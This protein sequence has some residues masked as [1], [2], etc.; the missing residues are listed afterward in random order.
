MSRS[1]LARWHRLPSPLPPPWIAQPRRARFASSTSSFP[2]PRPGRNTWSGFVYPLLLLS[3]V[4]SLTMNLR[5]T[6][7]A[8]EEN[9]RLLRSQISVLESLVKWLKSDGIRKL[10]DEEIERR[11]QRELELVGLRERQGSATG[12]GGQ[13]ETL[14]RSVTWKE[15]LL[16]RKDLT[17]PEDRRAE[18]EMVADLEKRRESPGHHHLGM[19]LTVEPAVDS[20]SSGHDN[21]TQSAAAVR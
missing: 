6:R 16:G 8:K 4:T 9:E 7:I 12:Q 10:P 5:N 1:G 14:A 21:V 19:L 15:V 17:S 11:L 13:P 2:E 18:D 20:G 3:L